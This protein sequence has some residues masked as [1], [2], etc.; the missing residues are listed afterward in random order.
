MLLLQFLMKKIS[1]LKTFKMEVE[2]VH[3]EQQRKLFQ[4][5]ISSPFKVF[6]NTLR[7]Q[8]IIVKMFVFFQFYL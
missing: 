7:I 6:S 4:G 2:C 1:R 8:G 3:H 5:V